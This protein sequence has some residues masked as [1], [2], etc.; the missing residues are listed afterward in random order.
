MQSKR[1]TTANGYS[2][3]LTLIL[4]LAICG[5]LYFLIKSHFSKKDVPTYSTTERSAPPH[6]SPFSAIDSLQLAKHQDS[7][8]FPYISETDTL[9]THKGY[10]LVYQEEWEQ[11]R[12]V[13]WQIDA[14]R[15]LAKAERSSSFYSDPLIHSKSAHPN[16]YKNS[17]YDR[18]HLAPA[19]DFSH[20]EVLMKESFYMSNMSPQVPSF[21]RGIWKKLEEHTRELAQQHA[22]LYVVAGPIIAGEVKKIG[23]NQVYVPTYYFKI[24]ADLDTPGLKIAAFILPNQKADKA[25]ASFQVAVDSVERLSGLNF[26]PLLPDSLE[27]TLE[28]ELLSI[29]T[30]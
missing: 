28:A 19:A 10:S 23:A 13:A 15:G 25:I 1:E 29:D 30:W 18:G 14:N 22:H 27:Q 8:P 4:V 12:W 6:T 7:F 5:V 17:G 26:F 24:I 21:N 20:D 2:L 11:A 16:D 3:L 9:I